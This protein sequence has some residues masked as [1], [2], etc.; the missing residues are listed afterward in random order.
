MGAK[1]VWLGNPAWPGN[2]SCK[3]FTE[4][5]FRLAGAKTDKQ[6]ALAFYDWIQRCMMRGA[7]LDDPERGRRLLA[8][9]RPA[10]AADQL[11]LRRV[12][13][14][15]LGLHGVPVRSRPE[16]AAGRGPQAGPH[17]LR[18]LVQGR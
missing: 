14:L 6:K 11:G 15:G 18:G 2:K 8:E 10:A 13:L 12:H 16:G 17:L 1:G 4:D 9:L 5:V 3:Q 7:N